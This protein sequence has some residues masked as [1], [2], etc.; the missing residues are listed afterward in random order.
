M[1]FIYYGLKFFI[2]YI[3]CKYLFRIL[4]AVFSLFSWCSFN[5]DISN[6][7][8]SFFVARGLVAC[9][10]ILLVCLFDPLP[11]CPWGTARY[12]ESPSRSLVLGTLDEP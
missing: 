6:L 8:D 4:W 12:P 5:F 11:T 9:L 10:C 2:R 1:F 7:S 3:I